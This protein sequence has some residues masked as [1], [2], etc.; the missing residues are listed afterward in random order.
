MQQPVPKPAIALS[1]GGKGEEEE[2]GK[3]GKEKR[4]EEEQAS[5]RVEG[6]T[7]PSL[8]KKKKAER[9]KRQKEEEKA[10]KSGLEPPPRKQQKVGGRLACAVLHCM[11]ANPCPANDFSCDSQQ[12]MPYLRTCE[13]CKAEGA[14]KEYVHLNFR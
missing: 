8:Q 4:E 12:S 1:Y 10:I 2:I 14:F 7:C 13:I 3:E 5:K 9:V 11:P 6:C